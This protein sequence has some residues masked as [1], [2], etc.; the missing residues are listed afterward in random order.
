MQLE[1]LRVWIMLNWKE[2]YEM[3]HI[4]ISIVMNF[5]LEITCICE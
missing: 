3:Y 2:K 4:S 1:L 5:L